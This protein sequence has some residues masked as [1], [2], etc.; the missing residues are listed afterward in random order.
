MLD[1]ISV[2]V[3]VRLEA[4]YNF[5]FI[6]P[7]TTGPNSTVQ[8]DI[9][10][11]DTGEYK[12]GDSDKWNKTCEQL[13]TLQ[14]L[15][16]GFRSRE[17]MGRFVREVVCTKLDDLRSANRVKYAV[18]QGKGKDEMWFRAFVGEEG[19]K[20]NCHSLSITQFSHCDMCF[21]EAPRRIHDLWRI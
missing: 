18:L 6:L 1:M 5:Y 19:L 7:S 10:G 14:K 13:P 9:I 20:G 11:I 2:A 16:L 17:D 15:V 12:R 21:T 4:S 3:R 8:I